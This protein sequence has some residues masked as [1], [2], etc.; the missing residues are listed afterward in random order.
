VARLGRTSNAYRLQ[1]LEPLIIEITNDPELFGALVVTPPKDQ[2]PPSADGDLCNI[3]FRDPVCAPE[4]A[5]IQ[6]NGDYFFSGI[7]GPLSGLFGGRN[8][9]GGRALWRLANISG[10]KKNGCLPSDNP[11]DRHFVHFYVHP[12]YVYSETKQACVM[13]NVSMSWWLSKPVQAYLDNEVTNVDLL[14][15]LEALRTPAPPDS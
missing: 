2:D 4:P 11:G 14:T 15:V 6:V 5:V 10:K 12:Q 9:Q 8:A 3:D 7:R 1:E 13:E